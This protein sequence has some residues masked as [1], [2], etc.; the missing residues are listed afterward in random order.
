MTAGP[1]APG[2]ALPSYQPATAVD[3]G[4]C[5]EPSAARPS[6]ITEVRTPMSGMVSETGSA[7]ADG[8]TVWKPAGPEPG[9]AE[10]AGRGLEAE[11]AAV[12]GACGAVAGAGT[13]ATPRGGGR[14][15]GVDCLV[16]SR[17]VVPATTMARPAAAIAIAAAGL[18][19]SI[20]IPV[21]Y[22]LAVNRRSR[23]R[24]R[25]RPPAMSTR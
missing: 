23:V 17:P 25:R 4:T 2:N 11:G 14:R 15:A 1:M 12:A 16:S 18:V 13:V 9:D 8:A 5:I 7:T 3:A 19:T 21:R 10:R 6:M 20:G 24:D 22:P